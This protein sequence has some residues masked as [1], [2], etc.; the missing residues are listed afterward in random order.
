M[1]DA[2]MFIERRQ[3][4]RVQMALP[5]KFRVIDDQREIETLLERR[6]RDQTSETIDLSQGG[7]YIAAPTELK[8]GTILRLDVQVGDGAPNISAFAEVVWANETGAGLR[9]L[10]MKEEDAQRLKDHL[11]KTS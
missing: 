8:T 4:P 10:A 11:E 3:H 6:K 1:P 2:K 9:F 7:A 5:I